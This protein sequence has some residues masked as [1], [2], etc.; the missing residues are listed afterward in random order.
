MVVQHAVRVFGLLVSRHARASMRRFM[1][2]RVRTGT[3]IGETYSLPLE[4]LGPEDL[5][6]EKQRL[7]LQ[8]KS[9]FGSTMP[10]FEVY[11]VTPDN[12]LHVPRFYGITRFGPAESDT[13]TQGNAIDVVFSGSLT[14]VQRRASDTAFGDAY[15]EGGNGGGIFVLPC[16][17]GKTVLA[18]HTTA[19]LG[20][21]TAVLVHT[22]VLRTQWKE[23]FE[24][25]CPGI[26]V[27]YVQGSTFDVEGKDVVI[28]MIQTVA[29][30]QFSADRMDDFGFLICDEAHHMAAPMMNQA[31]RSF[32]AR[33]I[34]ALTATKERAD[35]LTHLLHWSLGP[36]IFRAQ[37]TGEEAVRVSIVK[38]CGAVND[39]TTRDGKPLVAVMLNKLAVH[40]R[41]NA[42]LADRI[43]HMRSK[44]RV[45]IVLSH[46]INQLVLLR[47]LLE[48]RL[49][50]DEIG[51][52][53]TSL[54]EA[55]RAEQIARPVL[56][57][58]YQMADEGL[59]KKSLDTCV[60]ASPKARVEQCI[61]RI[62]RPCET[63][64]APLVVDVADDASFFVRLEQA[65]RRLYRTHRYE[66][67]TI[68][69]SAQNDTP[70][71]WFE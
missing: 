49:P 41:R 43:C 52:L 27:G 51:M 1:Q 44:G 12:R 4:A 11:R 15:S 34:A 8:Q 66:T 5:E 19:K 39:I 31:T 70:G 60:M 2:P 48:D 67:Q 18:V 62:Q 10:P 59:D 3:I 54:N 37:R 42:L 46:R 13:R 65:R 68:D 32:R 53:Q 50:K 56:L 36:E 17:L 45:I 38:F 28:M 69:P 9:T 24:K 26:K 58:S 57:C 47:S 64:Q 40:A 23:S 33:Y 6:D 25:F 20:R 29:K 63:K 21:K 30:R 14:E 61:G 55:A 7:T 71:M 16:G 22:S 35:G